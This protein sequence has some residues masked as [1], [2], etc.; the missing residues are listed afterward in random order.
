MPLQGLQHF[1]TL[2]GMLNKSKRLLLGFFILLIVDFVWVSSS[3]LT[4]QFF[5][6][7]NI[8]NPFFCTYVKTCLLTF[9]LLGAYFSSQW[10][11]QCNKSPDYLHLDSEIEDD[12]TPLDA[13]ANLSPPIFVPIKQNR[14]PTSGTEESDD[15]S[16]NKAVRFSKVAEVRHMSEHDAKAALFARLSYHASL[17]AG[18]TNRY[19]S[20]RFKM[21]Q[22]LKLS[23]VFCFL[24]FLANYTYQAAVSRIGTQMLVIV[25]SFSSLFTL[26]FSPIFSSNSNDRITLSKTLATLICI[27][28]L[29]LVSFANESSKGSSV[30]SSLAQCLAVFSAFFYSL[31]LV[32]LKKHMEQEERLIN[33]QLFFG[34]I[35]LYTVL[36]LWPL[37]FLLHYSEWETFK[38]PSKHQWLFLFING[39]VSTMFSQVLWL[40]SCFLTSPLIAATAIALTVPLES[41][42]D[43]FFYNVSYASMFYIG[44]LLIIS[45]YFSLF[46]MA[47]LQNKDPVLE[48]I[49]NFVC[50]FKRTKIVRISESDMEQR[51]SLIGVVD[52]DTNDEHEA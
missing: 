26:I 36:L 29:G 2:P 1:E 52:C 35:G 10:R 4:K 38:W 34:F 6:E 25:A 22:S 23:F 43:I 32:F 18:E 27:I 24:W 12:G 31:C 39:L 5:Q 33:L 45:S 13:H 37:F 21:E 19:L 9:Y 7:E 51:E 42:I 3:E 50:L 16:Q 28:G 20:E 15:G 48:L 11:E 46:F 40:W 44:A 47:H 41:M 14:T 49:S 30:S 8:E 17:R